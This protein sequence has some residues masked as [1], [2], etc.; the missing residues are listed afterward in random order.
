MPRSAP[1]AA[2][3]AKKLIAAF[4][5]QVHEKALCLT[6]PVPQLVPLAVVKPRPPL[7]DFLTRYEP[8]AAESGLYGHQAKVIEAL[9]RLRLP[10]VLM[11]TATGSG[12]SLAFWAWA[13]ELLTR[14]RK[15]TLIATFPTQALLWGQAK[16]LAAVSEPASMVRS[17]PLNGVCF[18]GTIRAG[19]CDIPW[20]VWY[21]VSGC[22]YMREHE[23][24]EAFLRARIRVCT[25]DKV[26][27]SLMHGREAGF[28][29]RLAG[30]IVDEAH[31]WHGI[32]GA[33]VRAMFDRLRLSLDMLRCPYPSF[34]LGSATLAEAPAFA[35]ALTGVPASSFLEVSDRGAAR[36]SLVEARDVPALLAQAAEPGFLRRYVF[37][38][39]PEPKPLAARSILAKSA[40]LGPRAN[41]LCFVQSKF[42]GHR[43]RQDLHRALRSREVVVYDADLPAKDRRKLEDQLFND[44]G[45]PK[46]VVGTCAL[47]LGVDLPTLDV[48]V[49]DDLPPRRCDLLQRLGRVGRSTDRPGLGV[50]CLGYSA[51]DERLLQDPAGALAPDGMKPLSLPLHLD[52]VR[53]Q[54][55]AAAFAEWRWR[56]R[57]GRA[58]WD[59]FNAALKRHFGWAPRVE[60]LQQRIRETLGDLVDLDDGAW[61]YKGFR[62]SASQGKCPLCLDGD[63]DAVVAIIEDMSIFRD[64]H[65]EGVYLGHRGACYRVRNYVG[66]WDVST[67]A[68]PSGVILSKYMKGLRRIEVTAERPTVATRGRWKDTFTLDEPRELQ[69][70]HDAPARGALTFGL[71]TFLRKFDGYQEIDLRGRGRPKTVTLAEVAQRFNAAIERGES[72]PF[73]HNFSYRTKGWTWLGADVLGTAHRWALA[74]ILGPLLHEFLCDAVEC[75]TKDL[76]AVLE[77]QAGALWVVDATPGGNGLSEALLAEGRVAATLSSAA[78][79]LRAFAG[80]P[81]DAFRRYLLEEY[82][83]ESQMSAREVLDAV[84]L[85][86]AAWNG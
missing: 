47:E 82:R 76:E 71:F 12:K 35:Q 70:G 24:S 50:L 13:V 18:S 16:R 54:A 44:Q 85:V 20:S 37:L 2:H 5:D 33:N 80:Q 14:N 10:S 69:Q 72:F 51:G 42:V 81:N 36:E 73:L 56:F 79:R 17:T 83:V 31:S 75:S 8:R 30:I 61:F 46:V 53:L 64:A 43:L 78:R 40:H 7:R 21:G 23:R 68:G 66:K 52:V 58:S 55:M 49:M 86:A 38:M 3:V 9:H 28:L 39:R 45:K 74:S 4:G 27:W 77:A 26:H 84:E 32:S 29:S 22:E 41:A 19:A 1:P 6:T 11:T 34:F 60:E 59:G 65:P 48:V 67:W 57:N 62:A 63:G 25:L 15:A